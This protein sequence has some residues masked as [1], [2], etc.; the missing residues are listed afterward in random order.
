MYHH[1][2]SDRCSNDYAIFETHLAY[3]SQH[4]TTLFPT[5]DKLPKNPICLVFDDGYYDFYKLTFPL[6][7]KYN[8]KALLAVVPSVTLEKSTQTE[9]VRLAP[10]HNELFNEFQNGTF[11]S[12]EELQE[13]QQS[14]HVQIAS[15]SLTHVNLL[16][17]SADVTKE[18]KESKEILEQKLGVSV[19]SFVFP[20]G[21]YNQQILE[22][23]QKYYKYAFRIGNGINRDF[24]GINGVIYRI[25][26]D[27]LKDA[28][29]VFSLKNMLRYAFKT[30]IKKVAGNR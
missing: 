6:L 9:T 14:G 16:E 21:K 1:L 2:N 28:H 18:L 3:I 19:D 22:E 17:E 20:F 8:L 29:S 25:D 24:K 4:Y 23:T 15:H 26:G 27:N 5:D 10:E 12:Y 30:L 7:K 11:C 13:M